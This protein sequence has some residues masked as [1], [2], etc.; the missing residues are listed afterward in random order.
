MP[1][2]GAVP[3]PALDLGQSDSRKLADAAAM[4]GIDWVYIPALAAS[5]ALAVGAMCVLL[6][7]M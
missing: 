3:Y 7:G 5:L 4:A 1:W 2:Q 6:F